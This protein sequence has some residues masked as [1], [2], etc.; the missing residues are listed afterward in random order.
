MAGLF[1]LL[2]RVGE[3]EC[4]LKALSSS[5]IQWTLRRPQL[6]AIS[7]DVILTSRNSYVNLFYTPALSKMASFPLPGGECCRHIFRLWMKAFLSDQRGLSVV[8]ATCFRV[9]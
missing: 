7:G 8:L 9:V 5:R 1:V 6:N 4:R 3:K 2:P